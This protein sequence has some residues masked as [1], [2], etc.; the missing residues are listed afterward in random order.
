MKTR[1]PLTGGNCT[2][3]ASGWCP[4]TSEV[5][6]LGWREAVCSQHFRL[7]LSTLLSVTA[8]GHRSGF[9][10]FKE[11]LAL[12][13]IRKF[14]KSNLTIF[15]TQIGTES[16][17]FPDKRLTS[18]CLSL[19]KVEALWGALDS[20]PELQC[21]LYNEGFTIGTIML[22]RWWAFYFYTQFSRNKC[23]PETATRMTKNKLKSTQ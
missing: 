10:F 12:S 16:S 11:F 9:S 15:P 22:Y 1:N 21:L 18:P 13:K 20:T 5:G 3:S 6:F 4:S 23:C 7:V 2:L 8:A 17:K 14:W 19:L